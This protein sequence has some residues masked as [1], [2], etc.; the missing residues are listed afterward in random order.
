LQ[1]LDSFKKTTL[2]VFEHA[3]CSSIN[4]CVEHFHLH[5]V[6]AK[7]DVTWALKNL[8]P[9]LI[10][11]T[12]DTGVKN[13]EPYL[14]AARVEEGKVLKGYIASVKAKDDQFFRRALAEM[15]GEKEWDWRIGMNKHFMLNLVKEAQCAKQREQ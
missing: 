5:V 11:V 8:D 3:G 7:Y 4:S 6:K 2:F 13:K 15:I 10:N 9:K 1:V 12:A 14:L